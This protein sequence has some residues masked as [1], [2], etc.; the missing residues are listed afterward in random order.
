MEKISL[1]MNAW[2]KLR[3]DLATKHRHI[4]NGLT[5]I[6]KIKTDKRYHKIY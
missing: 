3:T 6:E 2:R 1:L 5:E 4:I